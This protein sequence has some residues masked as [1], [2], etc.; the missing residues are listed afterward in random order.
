MVRGREAD[1]KGVAEP[2]GYQLELP[3][4]EIDA[5][6]RPVATDLPLDDLARLGSSPVRDE[7]SGGHA[8]II[9]EV[10]AEQHDIPAGEVVDLG[11]LGEP[12][13]DFFIV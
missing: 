11:V 3:G 1:P 2:P 7:G 10:P 6:D 4:F 12:A 9:G 5:E 13:R 8:L